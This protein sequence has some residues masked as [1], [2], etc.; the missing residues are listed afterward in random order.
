MKLPYV[1]RLHQ[2]GCATCFRGSSALQD[3]LAFVALKHR[4]GPYR[5]VA[6]GAQSH[7][8]IENEMAFFISST[9]VDISLRQP[10]LFTIQ[11]PVT[12]V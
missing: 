1:M 9:A 7:L 5:I 10:C 11:G 3:P 4:T 6:R 8:G 2:G 12:P